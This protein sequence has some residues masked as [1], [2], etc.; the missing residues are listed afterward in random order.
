M[1]NLDVLGFNVRLV[2]TRIYMFTDK[3]VGTCD[4]T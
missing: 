4:F 2:L 1:Y 3:E